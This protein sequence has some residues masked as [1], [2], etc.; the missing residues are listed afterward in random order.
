M[1]G[2]STFS[3]HSWGKRVMI[4]AW[5]RNVLVVA[6]TAV[7]LTAAAQEKGEN[8]ATNSERGATSVKRETIKGRLPR[9]FASLV[10]SEQKIEIYL[11]QAKFRD[12][13]SKLK[14][15]LEKLESQQMQDI[16]AVLTTDQRQKLF[17][18]RDSSRKKRSSGTTKGD[19]RLPNEAANDLPESESSANRQTTS[20]AN[21]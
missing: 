7:C 10:N 13:I 17:D 11:I 18:F 21:K 8:P 9:Y 19:P 3:S 1:F 4:N 16:E 5:G 2:W 20:P 12:Q 15:E 6:F 14:L